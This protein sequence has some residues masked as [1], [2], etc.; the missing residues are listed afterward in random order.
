MNRKRAFLA[1]L[2]FVLL[3]S[4][5]GAQA[6]PAPQ[7][8]DVTVQDVDASLHNHWFGIYS[9]NKK[10]GYQNVAREKMT[11]NGQT[12]YRERQAT[13][14][15]LVVG[16]QKLETRTEQSLDFDARPPFNLMRAQF[17]SDDGKV[18]EHISL[19]A[20]GKGY[21]VT[22]VTGKVTE[23]K[24]LPGLDFT[25]AD[26]MAPEMWLKTAP[27]K[28]ATFTSRTFSFQDQKVIVDNKAKLLGTKEIMDNGLPR[29]VH[30]V[31][32]YLPGSKLSAL[33]RLDDKAHLLSIAI[34]DVV[35]ARRESEAE[36]KNIEFGADLFELCL[37]KIDQPLGD[38]RQAKGLVVE[39]K[40]KDMALL[41]NGQL[42]T[43]VPQ[44]D[45]VYLIKVGKHHGTQVKATEKE[46]REAL[47]PTAEYP[48]GDA[49][50]LEL[51]KK[52]IGDATTDA[53]KVKRLCKFVHDFIE[54]SWKEAGGAAKVHDIMERKCG[55]CRHYA[56]LFTC[57][58]RAVGVP[59]R[60]LAGV[61]YMG[62]FL[63]N[64]TSKEFAPHMWN[65]VLLDGSWV[66]VDSSLNWTELGV[67]HIC[68]GT[69]D[70]TGVS[71]P[72]MGKQTLKLIELERAQ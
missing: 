35:E 70:G 66:P 46:I 7:R 12:F 11:E 59:S 54:P 45:D 38:W 34:P 52:A 58:S 20:A 22:L 17:S 64:Q 19:A 49:K 36:A 15:R 42:Q 62:L 56:V 37:V 29:K 41:P 50:V 67:T 14:S 51:A 43:I 5:T 23:K 71:F 10:I 40:G 68:L 61:A 30:E 2:V 31:E 48:I 65:E 47:E 8:L 3:A 69:R 39:V 53:E 72:I 55:V 60:E 16:G 63:G 1:G 28:G 26:A 24:T 25:L 44:G 13:H 21:E 32:I 4:L 27:D 9:E 18:Q 6:P 57:L 33:C